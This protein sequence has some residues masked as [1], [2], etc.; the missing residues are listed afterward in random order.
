MT[1]SATKWD[2]ELRGFQAPFT[3]VQTNFE[4]TKTPFT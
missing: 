4:R 1:E 2:I 3:R